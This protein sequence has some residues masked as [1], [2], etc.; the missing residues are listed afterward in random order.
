VGHRKPA[1]D[2]PGRRRRPPRIR[3]RSQ[4]GASPGTLLADPAAPR[5][6]IQVFAFGPERCVERADA[7]LAEIARLRAQSPVVWVDVSGLGDAQI[8]AELGAAFGL[9]PLWLEDV[10]NVHQ[11]PKVEREGGVDF[12]VVRALEGD[13]ALGT[14][15]TSLFLGP[16]FV[17][18]FQERPG[19]CF[20][21]VRA[22]LRQPGS[23][24]RQR[25][26]DYLA[27]AL[28]DGVIDG[29]FPWIERLGERLEQLED[30]LLEVPDASCLR[31]LHEL[32]RDLLL[33][34]RSVWPLREVLH[35][36]RREDDALI[37]AETRL[38]LSDSYDHT[39]QIQD[40]VESD[41][42]LAAGLV[43]LYLSSASTRLNEIM[44]FLT[45]ISTVFI[46]LTFVVG[47]YGMNFRPEAGPWSMPELNTPWG[48]VVCM[49][50][51]GLAALWMILWFWRR[52]WLFD[53]ARSRARRAAPPTP[54]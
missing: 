2:K 25:G 46:P 30:R 17:L 44:R 8:V 38:F 49:A 12:L 33:V 10:L 14:D 51:M 24:L 1:H 53:P 28:I 7:D 19:D 42:E 16:G 11:R 21:P 15:Q 20:D 50:V 41:R 36:L 22:R 31:E 54:P 45:V 27:Y 9:H 13:G 39:L 5:P 52:G 3:R 4:P 47:V 32:R 43:E 37:G 40:L 6:R 23:R 29:Y 18:T 35:Q 34:R 48:Y 26:P